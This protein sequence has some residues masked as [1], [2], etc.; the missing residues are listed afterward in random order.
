M[1]TFISHITELFDKPHAWSNWQSGG[2]EWT[3]KFPFGQVRGGKMVPCPR[4]KDEILKFYESQGLKITGRTENNT[5]IINGKP[6]NI[7]GAMYTVGFHTLSSAKNLYEDLME[8]SNLEQSDMSKIWE[9]YFYRSESILKY[10][11]QFG[12]P[13]WYWDYDTNKTG[14]DDDLAIMSGAD[15]AMILGTVIDIGKDF[16]S[17]TNPKGI[18]IGTKPEAKDVRGRIYIAMARRSGAQTITIPYAPRQ[19]MKHG[20]MVWFDKTKQFDPV[21]KSAKV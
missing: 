19:G 4:Q 13:G 6:T 17:K 20:A 7:R 11:T 21:A 1:K 14:S 8:R 10:N 5:P 12:R 2:D 16:V 18:L 3:Y 9:L 15:A